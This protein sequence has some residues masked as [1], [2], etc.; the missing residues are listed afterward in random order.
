[1]LVLAAGS[2]TKDNAAYDRLG[3]TQDD[4]GLTVYYVAC[5][6]ERVDEVALWSLDGDSTWPDDG[7]VKQ[8]AVKQ[9]S[10]DD[11][12]LITLKPAFDALSSVGGETVVLVDVRS[13][14]GAADSDAF[15]VGK[16]RAG[17]FLVRT[18][19]LSEEVFLARARQSC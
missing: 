8:W 9:P 10:T 19:L 7:D 4:S 14:A 17:Q 13:S 3:I 11:D 16:L 12:G 5:P 15:E 1:M 18:K 6:G 2:C